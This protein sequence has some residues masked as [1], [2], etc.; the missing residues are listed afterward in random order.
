[1]GT[2]STQA[3]NR[4]P[5][6]NRTFRR[7]TTTSRRTQI[8]G[9]CLSLSLRAPEQLHVTSAYTLPQTGCSVQPRKLRHRMIGTLRSGSPSVQHAEVGGCTRHLQA[10]VLPVSCL[11]S[12]ATWFATL[13][14]RIESPILLVHAKRWRTPTV[15]PHAPHPPMAS[16]IKTSSSLCLV[17]CW[18]RP[19]PR[20]LHPG[21]MLHPSS[22]PR[23][24]SFPRC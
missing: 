11:G 6:R 23:A 5:E 10:R 19:K 24:S 17:C 3:T 2:N 8:S 4:Q 22:L 1:M 21:C 9:T 18:L 14:D 20:R 12:T 13:R 16:S 7:L 15:E